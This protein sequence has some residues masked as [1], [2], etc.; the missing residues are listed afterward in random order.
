MHEQHLMQM[1]KWILLCAPK[2]HPLID[3]CWSSTPS[4]RRGSTWGVQ[5]IRVQLGKKR[6]SM[7]A[8][9]KEPRIQGSRGS[10]RLGSGF[11]AG[12]DSCPLQGC[13]HTSRGHSVRQEEASVVRRK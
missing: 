2:S 9:P 10:E 1:H 4:P 5:L 13:A 3:P 11:R 8:P 7:C 12:S 6:G